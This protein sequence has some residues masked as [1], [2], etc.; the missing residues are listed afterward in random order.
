M[1]MQHAVTA[2][3]DRLLQLLHCRARQPLRGRQAWRRRLCVDRSCCCASHGQTTPRHLDMCT[4]PG[5]SARPYRLRP[6]SRSAVPPAIYN[7]T[8]PEWFGGSQQLCWSKCVPHHVLAPGPLPAAPA[9]LHSSSSRSLRCWPHSRRPTSSPCH[10]TTTRSVPPLC[11]PHHLAR[12]TARR[13]PSSRSLT[14]RAAPWGRCCAPSTLWRRPLR[15][16]TPPCWSTRWR[17]STHSSRRA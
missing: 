3:G 1:L 10:R 8:H 2:S 7:A 16:R 6:A 5:P 4:P 12:T 15:T 11:V 13:P 14:R 17:T 9:S